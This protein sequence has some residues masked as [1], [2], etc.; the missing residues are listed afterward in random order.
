M[1]PREACSAEVEEREEDRRRSRRILLPMKPGMGSLL[2]GIALLVLGV[3]VTLSSGH[4]IWYGAMLVGV[5][6]IIRGLVTL[7]SNPPDPQS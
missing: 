1:S 3:G 2:F 4:V 5:Y 6:R 7:S